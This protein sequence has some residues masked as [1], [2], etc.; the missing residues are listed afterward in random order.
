MPARHPIFFLSQVRFICL[1]PSGCHNADRR[2]LFL[3]QPRSPTIS[4]F[5]DFRAGYRVTRQFQ[6]LPREEVETS[7]ERAQ[8]RVW[9]TKR[10]A[11]VSSQSFRLR[12]GRISD[13]S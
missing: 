7:E 9:T 1:T 5:S 2:I 8:W 10:G 4:L 12:G 3:V 11:I 13:V 6:N